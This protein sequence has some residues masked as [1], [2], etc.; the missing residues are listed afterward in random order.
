MEA[1]EKHTQQGRQHN[2]PRPDIRERLN[3]LILLQTFVFCPTLIISYS[4]QTRD[5]L[6]RRQKMRV[7]R[8]IGKPYQNTDTDH[9]RKTSK[10]NVDDF[11][12]G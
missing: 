3:Y 9:D 4:L 2:E 6:L 5:S 7:Y 8:R 10:E 1:D 12:G 11:V